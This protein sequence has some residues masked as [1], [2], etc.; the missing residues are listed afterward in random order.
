MTNIEETGKNVQEAT[1]KALL[2][3]GVTED[4]VDVEI[5]EEGTKGFLGIGQKT[6]AR[7]RVTLRNEPTSESK[8][9]RSRR[10]SRSQNQPQQRSEPKTEPKPKERPARPAP[11]PR[12]EPKR[13]QEQKPKPEPRSEPRE[14]RVPLSELPILPPETVKEAA[15]FGRD[16]LQRMLDALGNGGDASVKTVGETSISLE[17]R[18]GDAPRL[19]GRHGQTINAMQYL[20]GI[21]LNRKYRG[22]LRTVL[23]VEDYRSHREE[24]LHTQALALAKQVKETG[25]EAVLESLDANDRR[26]IHSALADDPDVKTYS[27][28]EEPERVLVISPKD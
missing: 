26:V 6:P 19:I 25:Q 5:L 18:G 15:E 4:E 22:K 12:E 20:V 2:Q 28:G 27:E 8:R 16:L 13:M 9:S 17:I 10:P 11:K 14:P 24:M 1:E 21:S 7:V 23:D 3:L